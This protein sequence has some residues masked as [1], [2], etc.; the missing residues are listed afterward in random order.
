[1][2]TRN[3]ALLFDAKLLLLYS[4]AKL[5]DH[6]VELEP[7][8]TIV[9]RAESKLF[10]REFAEHLALVEATCNA[11]RGAFLEMLDAWVNC[12]ASGGKIL[13]FGNGGSA[14]DAQHLASELV[15]RYR[16]DRPAIAAIC[17]SAD[18]SILTAGG[19]DLGFEHVFS[20]QIEALGR[21]GD[22]AFAISTSGQSP[23]ILAGLKSARAHG[24]IAAGMTGE[25]SSPMAEI[26]DPLIAVPSQTTAR[27][28]EMHGLIG[29][30]LCLSLER[31][32]KMDEITTA[33]L[34]RGR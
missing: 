7:E 4:A 21:P 20:R 27:I 11:T 15:V 8:A 31:A 25:N 6:A 34:K 24:L 29:H 2:L 26:A 12:I 23:N 32:L 18:S 28:Q 3:G 13:F 5:P 10:E 16:Q 1:V 30:I 33:A 22:I 19:N 9:A 17:L 14:A